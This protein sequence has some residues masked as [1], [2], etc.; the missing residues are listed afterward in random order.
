[1]VPTPSHGDIARRAYDIYLKTGRQ[2]GQCQQ[3]WRQAEQALTNEGQAACATQP[4][5]CGTSP[6]PHAKFTPVMK[7]VG[8]D[9]SPISH[10]GHS[11]RGVRHPVPSTGH[12]SKA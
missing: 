9:S 11:H 5:G 8:D 2:Q 6:E 10:G 1:M 7:T 3:N 4:C 12:G